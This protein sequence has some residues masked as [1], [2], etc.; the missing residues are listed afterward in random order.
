MTE[1]I[2]D[3]CAGIVRCDH[4][5]AAIIGAG[6]GRNAA[7]W[8]DLTYCFWAINEIPQSHFDRHL[9]MHP[10]AVQSTK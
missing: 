1:T 6:R 10:L 8:G 2:I 5:K 4:R 9:E 3:A 7:P